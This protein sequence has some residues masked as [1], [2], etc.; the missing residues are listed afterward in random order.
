MWLGQDIRFVTYLHCKG[1]ITF[2]EMGIETFLKVYR[3]IVVGQKHQIDRKEEK[4][5]HLAQNVWK[6]WTRYQLR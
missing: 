1:V 5:I 2:A 4:K 6:K 3:N